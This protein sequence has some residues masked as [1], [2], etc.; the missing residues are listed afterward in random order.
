M[1]QYQYQGGVW[2][3]GQYNEARASMREARASIYRPRTNNISL[4]SNRPECSENVK[5]L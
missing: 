1:G 2:D 3:Q 4:E 5:E